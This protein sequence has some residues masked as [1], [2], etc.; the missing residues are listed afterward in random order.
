MQ[1]GV[2]LVG[3]GSMIEGEKLARVAV[4]AEE[5]GFHSLWLSD[6]IVFST[7]MS[8][9]Y[10]YSPDGSLPIDPGVPFLECLTTLSYV[11]AV[12]RRIRLGSSVLIVPYR[13]PVLTAKVVSTLDV[14]SQG[15][16]IFGVGVGWLD[17]EFRAVG[18]RL[19]ERAARTRECLEVMKACW[20]KEDPEFHGQF[21]NFSGLKFAP[22][23][24][25]KPHPPIWFGG[26]TLPALRR[27]VEVGNGW[28]AAWLTPEEMK[29]K[30]ATLK[31]LADKAERNFSDIEITINVIG[32]VPVD[33][34]HVLRY[35]EVG[36]SMMFMPRVWGADADDIVRQM[37][38][39]AKEVKEPA[40]KM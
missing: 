38:K 6:H 21:F 40:E 22:K 24:V 14:L 26:N 27:V 31:E 37:E 18:Q 17:E 30:V 10:P 29:P 4:R 28:H 8:S 25:Q 39:F 1:F 16:F 34:D 5:I 33:L 12:T 23:P 3:T 7:Q 11:A 20:T 15:R 36:V 32:K 35:Q 19:E 13:E 9:R 2:H